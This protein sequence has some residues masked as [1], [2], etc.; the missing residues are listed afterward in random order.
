MSCSEAGLLGST[1]PGTLTRLRWIITPNNCCKRF[2][3]L[4]EAEQ[5]YYMSKVEET[6][7]QPLQAVASKTDEG[8]GGGLGASVGVKDI[9]IVVLVVIVV[10]LCLF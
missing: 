9:I 4:K 6:P 8:K 1:Q 5:A 7:L 10:Y 2:D 3:T